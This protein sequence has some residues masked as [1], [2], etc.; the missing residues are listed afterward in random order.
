MVQRGAAGSKVAMELKVCA[1]ETDAGGTRGLVR[2]VL[3]PVSYSIFSNE[4]DVKVSKV[5]H[6]AMGVTIL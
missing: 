3:K 5:W 2:K 6:R 4:T 1:G